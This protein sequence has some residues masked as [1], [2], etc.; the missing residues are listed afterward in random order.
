MKAVITASL[1]AA[2][3]AVVDG[4]T[5]GFTN[6]LDD[7]PAHPRLIQNSPENRGS[8][9]HLDTNHDGRVDQSEFSWLE[10]RIRSDGL[11]HMMERRGS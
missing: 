10:V 11:P 9:Q 1:L 5:P 6:C 2:A 7:Q 4:T 3:A 8:W